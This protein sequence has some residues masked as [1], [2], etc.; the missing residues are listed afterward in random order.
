MNIREFE[1]K[2]EY[3]FHNRRL[4]ENALTHSSYCREHGLENYKCNERL[5]FLGDAYFDA[6]TGLALYEKMSHSREGVLSKTRSLDRK[7]TR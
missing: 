7:S 4:L 2:I 3:T 6:I 5:E 1:Q